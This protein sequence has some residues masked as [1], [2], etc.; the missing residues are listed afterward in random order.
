MLAKLVRQ[1]DVLGLTGREPFLRRPIHWLIEL[2]DDGNA[3]GITPTVA[4]TR[5]GKSGKQE[6]RGKNFTAAANYLLGGANPSNWKPDFLTGPVNEI[7]SKGLNGKTTADDKQK[8]FCSLLNEA[9]S[10]LPTNSILKAIICFLDKTEKLSDI[11]ESSTVMESIKD[12]TLGFRVGGQLALNNAQIKEWWKT[13]YKAL[14]REE[15]KGVKKNKSDRKIFAK[16][17]RDAFQSDNK[18][19]I[20]TKASP[21]VFPKIPLISFS[22]ASFQ[23]YGLGKRT[24]QLRLDTAEKTAAALKAMANDKNT[25]I[26]MGDQDVVFWA[27]VEKGKESLDC[28]FLTLIASA[29]TLAVRD[30]LVSTWGGVSK[31]INSASFN[32]I[33]LKKGSGRFAVKSMTSGSLGKVDENFKEYFKAIQLGDAAP[34]GI[35]LLAECTIPRK[36]GK[37]KS[38]PTASTYN[39]ILSTAWKGVPLSF[40]LLKIV[41]ARQTLELTKGYDADDK[42]EKAVFSKRLRARAALMQL[43]FRTNKTNETIPM[44]KTTHE[45][46]D[47]PAYL[48]GRVLALLDEI[49]NE[50]HKKATSSSPARR[51][52]GSASSTPVLVFPRLLKLAAIHLGAMGGRLADKLEHGVPKNMADPA[53]I[54][55]FENGSE[56][57]DGL[58]QLIARFNSDAKWPRILSLEEQGRF[59]IGFYYER[60]RQWPNFN[61]KKGTTENTDAEGQSDETDV[62]TETDADP[63]GEE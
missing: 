49:H 19:G 11:P 7:F 32:M 56:H 54:K 30:Y 58:K 31:D 18:R 40:S 53:H 47:H 50:V 26:K 38:S 46:Q 17:A 13:K 52:Y 35:N 12:E 63:N 33:L 36:Q 21:C 51:Y 23:S 41:L 55:F 39:A 24:A 25:H 29:D 22:S 9:G 6:E 4:A 28:D 48:C 59:A 16:P 8:E 34:T 44:S 37:K 27:S 15:L 57:F 45:S 14:R 3:L 1:A 10:A 20:L 62:G 43:Y 42:S 2:D 61:D 60:N 5:K